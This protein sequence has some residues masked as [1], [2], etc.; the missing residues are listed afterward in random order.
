[1]SPYNCPLGF[2]TP[3]KRALDEVHLLWCHFGGKARIHCRFHVRS[4]MLAFHFIFVFISPPSPSLLFPV[5]RVNVG[6]TM[7]PR[8]LCFMLLCL[9]TGS[10]NKGESRGT[11][12]SFM[13]GAGMFSN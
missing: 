8:G 6:T 1:M 13:S 3:C 2:E 9:Q 11:V 10:G 12:P 4:V 7:G 5:S